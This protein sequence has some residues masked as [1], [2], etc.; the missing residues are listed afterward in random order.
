M[1]VCIATPLTW[2]QDLF[3]AESFT[4]C[5]RQALRRVGV[6]VT[7]A[8]LRVNMLLAFGPALQTNLPCM[9]S[10][11][12]AAEPLQLKTL[13]EA[14]GISAEY[15]ALKPGAWENVVARRF[16]RER[17]K[18]TLE[19]GGVVMAEGLWDVAGPV[20]A[21]GLITEGGGTILTG[22]VG[23][24]EAPLSNGPATI[25]LISP[26]NASLASRM[27]SRTVIRNAIL[28]IHG[29]AGTGSEPG[30]L[31]GNDAVTFLGVSGMRTPWCAA[32]GEAHA[33]C[34]VE[35]L[36]RWAE[37]AALSTCFLASACVDLS[38]SR[39]Q[40][41]REAE[42]TF[43]ALHTQL[44]ELAR[45]VAS[46]P[47]TEDGAEQYELGMRIVALRTLWSHAAISMGR[48][49]DLPTPRLFLER[50]PLPPSLSPERFVLR[51]LPL[52]RDLEGGE[53]DFMCSLYIVN[54]VIGTRD[55]IVWVKGITAEPFACPPFRAR[56]ERRLARAVFKFAGYAPE[57]Y[58]CSTNTIPPTEQ[59][60]RRVIVTAINRG[61]PVMAR[62]LDEPRHWSVIVGYKD[63]GRVLVAR[64][65]SDVKRSFWE[66]A[67]LPIECY[68]PGQRLPRLTNRETFY[69]AV[70]RALREYGSLT[71]AHGSEGLPA[72]R[73]WHM[74]VRELAITGEAPSLDFARVN[75]ENWVNW[76]RHRR[77]AYRFLQLA[78]RRVLGPSPQLLFAVNLLVAQ[79]N[80]LNGALADK[81]V[82][83]EV[84]G[85]AVPP[86]WSSSGAAA[87]QA[88]V[89][90]SLISN[91]VRIATVLRE[92]MGPAHTF[93]S[94]ERE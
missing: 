84:G 51:A 76:L 93:D 26:T 57:F 54:Y 65:P 25:V 43:V 28:H 66:T 45:A 6:N 52:Y 12:V 39:V 88:D 90:A 86:D 14:Y 2:G 49:C 80:A 3:Y 83:R 24:V 72:L 82:L 21:W 85:V 33:R 71:N 5:L 56:R 62:G 23:G 50:P 8:E 94:V 79:V 91:E 53:D 29:G 32:C 64:T 31:R 81:I 61:L 1:C 4:R 46:L 42:R 75:G 9:Y 44:L 59:L 74:D 30:L 22:L 20:H 7:P 34:I 15:L 19:D 35:V 38:G 58:F 68:V 67:Y 47:R 55:P 87:A 48:A 78:A 41:M 16:A 92:M 40:L 89:M 77:D 69:R 60:L 37:D 13:G 17:V 36:R 10:A 63:F 11:C 70:R 27:L 18:Q 73:R